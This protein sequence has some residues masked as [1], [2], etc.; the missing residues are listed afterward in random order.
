MQ[1]GLCTKDLLSHFPASFQSDKVASIFPVC[2]SEPCASCLISVLYS[3]RERLWSSH[4]LI[5]EPQPPS[6]LSLMTLLLILL[7]GVAVGC[8]L[9]GTHK[10]SWSLAYTSLVFTG[11]RF[12]WLHIY[13]V[14]LWLCIFSI[15]TLEELCGIKAVT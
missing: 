5:S 6:A 1:L 13:S 8:I 4:R 12:L 9:A 7:P 2:Q 10:L 11:G 14:F 3:G 15:F